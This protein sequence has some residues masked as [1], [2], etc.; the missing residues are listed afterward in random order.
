MEIRDDDFHRR[1]VLDF[2]PVITSE[3]SRV[4]GVVSNDVPRGTLTNEVLDIDVQSIVSNRVEDVADDFRIGYI[5]GKPYLRYRD[6]TYQEGDLFYRDRIT[7]IGVD[8]F[9][10]GDVIYR[11]GF[12]A[13]VADRE[14]INEQL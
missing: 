2:F 4:Y 6:R 3:L 5:C 8:N 12:P 11:V 9:V 10:V 13:L 1:L 7:S 14:I